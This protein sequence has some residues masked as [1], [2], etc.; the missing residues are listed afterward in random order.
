MSNLGDMVVRI[1]G[2][3]SELDKSINNSQAKM[4]KFG[5]TASKVGL[6][7]SVAFTVPIVAAGVAALKSAGQFQL[8]QA[9]FETMLGSAEKAKTLIG[10]MQT[11]AA[12]TPF[13]LTDLA[14]AG[15]TLLQFGTRLEDLM[16]ILKNLGDVSQG[17]SGRFQSLA[18][19]FGQCQSAGKLMGQDL[20]QMINAGF[21]PL[22]EISKK[23]GVSMA[24]LRKQMEKGQITAAMVA[25]SFSRAASAGGQFFG[26]MEKASKTLPGL[27]STLKDDLATMGRAFVQDLLPVVIN[28]VKQ[29]STLAQAFTTLDA[30]TK[31]FILTMLAFAAA[32]GP[33]LSGIGAITKALTFLAANPLVAAGIGIGIVVAGLVSFA[34][35]AEKARVDALA[36][37]FAALA[38]ATKISPEKIKLITDELRRLDGINLLNARKAVD[39]YAAIF[40]LTRQAVIDVGLATDG[41]SLKTKRELDNYKAELAAVDKVDEMKN[42]TLAAEGL[43]AAKLE[44]INKKERERLETYKKTRELQE[45]EAEYPLMP[46]AQ[47]AIDSAKASAENRKKLEQEVQDI[48]N[49]G[50]EAEKLHNSVLLEEDDK[51]S[52]A[53]AAS[54]LFEMESADAVA[55]HKEELEKEEEKRIQLLEEKQKEANEITINGLFTLANEISNIYKNQADS[56][57]EELEKEKDAEIYAAE[58]S[59]LTAEALAAKK[60][61]IEAKYVAEEKKIKYDADLASWNLNMAATIGAGVRAQMETWAKFG[62]PLGILP[63][64]MMAGITVAQIA[65]LKEAKPKLA[66]GGIVRA[67]PGGVDVTVAEG[68]QDEIIAPL[69]RLNEI[70]NNGGPNGGSSNMTH[71]IVQLDGKPFLDK[72]FPATKNG[73]VLISARAVV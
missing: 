6:M 61:E 65:A 37:E 23:T 13:E 5:S 47:A 8:Y 45:A 19:A 32:V 49:R 42:K 43:S 71:L 73:T 33:I 55:K 11:L 4:E 54:M 63:S 25:E 1:V 68:G 30:P 60:S 26:G 3:N 44:E 39:D 36:K 72:I 18:L 28:I 20:L 35:A 10:E 34:V 12:A 41:L 24:E 27:I 52:K 9:S 58:Q 21:N 69:E 51:N 59:G 62:W 2:D 56:K 22:Q 29:L 15:K 50:F 7:L 67:T 16:P 38:E 46:N 70:I 14:G 57:I 48:Q 40:H 17:E 31:T 66:N 53:V 64:I